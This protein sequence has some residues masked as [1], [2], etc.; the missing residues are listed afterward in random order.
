M[1]KYRIIT[2]I[3]KDIL[4]LFTNDSKIYCT[5]FTLSSL[6]QNY[7]RMSKEPIIYLK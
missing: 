1:C 5:F 3:P 2:Q 4:F 7:L 6:L